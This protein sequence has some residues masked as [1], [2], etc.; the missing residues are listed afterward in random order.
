MCLLLLVTLPAC[1]LWE[2]RDYEREPDEYDEYLEKSAGPIEE[3]LAEPSIGAS[4]AGGPIFTRTPA[5]PDNRSADLVEVELPQTDYADVKIEVN[6]NG[7]P[8]PAFINEV[9][10]NLLGESYTLDPALQ[11]LTD[12]VTLRAVGKQSLDD[13]A[14]MSA[15]VLGQYGVGI[16]REGRVMR[17]YPKLSRGADRPPLL[18]TGTALPDVPLSHRTIFQFV[19]LTVVRPANA[20]NWLERIF[21]GKSLE[22][23][24][25]LE[26]NSL[27][28]KGSPELVSYAIETIQVLDQPL[29]RGKFSIAISPYYLSARVLAQK[30]VDV[31]KAEGYSA[32]TSPPTGSV[33]VLP[34]EESESV[35]AFAGD[36]PTLDH[37]Q[38]WAI[39]LDVPSN[40]KDERLLHYYQVRNTQAQD[41]AADIQQLMPALRSIEA[42]A[43]EGQVSGTRRT[44]GNMVVVDE[45]RN[46]LVLNMT[47]SQWEKLLPI[48]RKMD[49][50]ARLVLVEV[51]LASVTLTDNFASGIDWLEASATLFDYDLEFQSLLAPEAGSLT[52]RV[53]NNAGD[54]KAILR[55]FDQDSRVNIL[56]RPH[57]MVKSGSE[58]TMEV[59]TEIPVVTSEVSAP[60]IPG[61][62]VNRNIQYRK[63]GLILSVIPTV[64][65][66][67]RVDLQVQQEVSEALAGG[68]DQENPSIFSRR[69]ISNLTLSN[70]GSVIIG[71]LIAENETYNT[72]QIP[73]LGDMPLIGPLFQQNR[74]ENT[75]NE[76]MILIQAYVVGDDGAARGATEALRK[77]FGEANKLTGKP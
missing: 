13:L 21:A 23:F 3:D 63:T 24:D 51:T 59:G 42:Q 16:A 71:G 72:E 64:H 47:A 48:L 45:N 12:L 55:L 74:R 70:G 76:V 30:L 40:N 27:L 38:D 22:V 10:G 44:E 39:R 28:L 69:V 35:V 49:R 58:A 57:V 5:A 52:A 14:K 7:I 50:P 67:D 66:G 41:M 15:D 19:P 29:M 43:S 31:L 68:A 6:F 20:T 53:L 36:Q 73:L 18:V 1:E 9:Y 77:R 60:D 54:V 37:I 8:L 26:R 61:G 25:D 33:I 11:G 65:S 34:I 62:S 17:F 2:P 4:A 32:S 75:R 46:G 56:S